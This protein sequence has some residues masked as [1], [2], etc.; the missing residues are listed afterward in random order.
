MSGQTYQRAF[1]QLQALADDRLQKVQPY[2][3]QLSINI[4]GSLNPQPT[5]AGLVMLISMLGP[6][7]CPDPL[8]SN[9]TVPSISA[10]K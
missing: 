2:L 5:I 4:P 10:W 6:T 1:P 9:R 8:V 7:C 3:P